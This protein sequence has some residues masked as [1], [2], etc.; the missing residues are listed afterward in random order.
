MDLPGQELRLIQL[1]VSL[2][3]ATVETPVAATAE[4][5][6]QAADEA[7]YQ[8]KRLGRDRVMAVLHG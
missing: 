6:L 8:A 7:L 4:R 2:G 3:V 5:L 1:T